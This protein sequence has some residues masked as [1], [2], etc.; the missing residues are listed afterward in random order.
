MDG[1][2]PEFGCTRKV[3]SWKSNEQSLQKLARENK[4]WKRNQQEWV[5]ARQG[6]ESSNTRK[7]WVRKDHVAEKSGGG[8]TD[9]I[10]CQRDKQQEGQGW[11]RRE[12]N[13][14]WEFQGEP[15]KFYRQSPRKRIWIRR[16]PKRNE[17]QQGV[18]N[19]RT[20]S[21]ALQQKQVGVRKDLNLKT[22][23]Q[24]KVKVFIQ[25]GVQKKLEKS[26][27]C[28][29]LGTE[30]SEKRKRS[31][32]WRHKLNTRQVWVVKGSTHVKSQNTPSR[33]SNRNVRSRWCAGQRCSK[34]KWEIARKKEN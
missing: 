12:I 24:E 22:S 19:G 1:P 7:V 4:R 6:L 10:T 17:S 11:F 2:E 21:E 33:V 27:V 32:R 15:K 14:K 5:D 9:Q 26:Q 20:H 28:A 16:D 13:L 25:K 18:F 30:Q 3:G 34:C 23:F 29:G 8:D 31:L